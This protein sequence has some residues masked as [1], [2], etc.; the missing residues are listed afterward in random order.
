MSGVLVNITHGR[1]NSVNPCHGGVTQTVNHRMNRI[2]QIILQAVTP[3]IRS[4]LS[5]VS[6]FLFFFSD[7]SNP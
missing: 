6:S 1:V 5:E 3:S 4:H 2:P 7:P